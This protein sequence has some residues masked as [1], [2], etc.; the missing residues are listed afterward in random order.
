MDY[1]ALEVKT[2]YSILN[3]LN[4][5]KKLVALAKNYGYSSLAITDENN[6]FGCYISPG[7]RKVKKYP[8]KYPMS[9]I[10]HQSEDLNSLLMRLKQIV[11]KTKQCERT[12][13]ITIYEGER[14]GINQWYSTT[15]ALKDKL[16][17]E[18]YYYG[19]QTGAI[20]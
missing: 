16:H 14:N 10:S 9:S 11:A 13:K 18:E 19:G 1:T 4:D 15:R 2:S 5:I 6:M 20:Q 8:M 12:I 7:H 3:S 17:D